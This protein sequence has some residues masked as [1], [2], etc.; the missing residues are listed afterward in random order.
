MLQGSILSPLLFLIYLNYLPN[1]LISNVK[2]FADDTSIF[3]NVNN[4]VSTDETNNDLKRISK[5]TYQW[6]MIFNPDITKQA[7]EVIFSWK[8]V[9]PFN[10]QILFEKFQ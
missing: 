8:K 6:K 3:S 1:N 5:W 7:Q 10:P 2:L 4:N 9:N